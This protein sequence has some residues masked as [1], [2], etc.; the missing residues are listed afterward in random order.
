MTLYIFAIATGLSWFATVPPTASL[1]REIY[2]PKNIGVL[3]GSIT[4]LHQIG[5]AVGV[6]VGGFIFDWTGTYTPAFVIAALL[7]FTATALSFS[8]R[9][10]FYRQPAPVAV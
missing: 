5:S 1:T 10:S 8:I 4:G 9:E 6:F 2:G 3:Y 7:L